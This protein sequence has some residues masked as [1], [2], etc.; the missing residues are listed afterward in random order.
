MTQE[1]LNVRINLYKFIIK[2]I[3]SWK[4]ISIVRFVDVWLLQLK[5]AFIFILFNLIVNLQQ[6]QNR[7]IKVLSLTI[8]FS[9]LIFRK[10]LKAKE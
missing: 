5:L 2:I 9:Q 7:K 4:R 3:Y 1:D 6:M 10:D 8:F